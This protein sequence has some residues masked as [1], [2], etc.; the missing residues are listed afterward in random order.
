MTNSCADSQLLC[1]CDKNDN[2]WRE[3]SGILTDKN[4][5]PVRQMR[6]SDTT[7]VTEEE[8]HTLGKLKCYGIA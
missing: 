3:D 5:L 1:N 6:F 8:Y 2:V 7:S 4:N